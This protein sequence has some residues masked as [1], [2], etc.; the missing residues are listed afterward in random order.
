MNLMSRK[1]FFTSAAEFTVYLLL[2]QQYAQSPSL[3]TPSGIP[4]PAIQ[5]VASRYTYWAIPANKI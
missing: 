4:S 2:Q 5:P 1:V 3:L